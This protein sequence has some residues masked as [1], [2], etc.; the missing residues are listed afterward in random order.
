MNVCA[1]FS[2]EQKVS[3]PLRDRKPTYCKKLG[4]VTRKPDFSLLWTSL[5][6]KQMIYIVAQITLPRYSPTPHQFFASGHITLFIRAE[7]HISSP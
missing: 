3:R 4:A 6:K 2:Y 1:K 7:T 5:V